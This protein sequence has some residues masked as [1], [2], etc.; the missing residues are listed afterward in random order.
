MTDANATPAKPSTL[1]SALI[2]ILKIVLSL[3][4]IY[5]VA[6]YVVRNWGEI[7]AYEW[8]IN[9]PLL[10]LSV[11]AHLL[12]LTIQARVWCMVMEGF[13]HRVKLSTSFK[14]SYIASLARYVPGKLWPM[15]GMAVL[16]KQAKID[17]R[18]SVASWAIAT[19]FGMPASFVVGGICLLIHSSEKAAEISNRLGPGMYIAA[20]LVTIASL[21]LLFAP[22]ITLWLYNLLLKLMKKPGVTFSLTIKQG[23]MIYLGYSLS[24]IAYGVSF[25]L[26]MIS[27]L[28][29]AN[30]PLV[31]AIGTFVLGYMIGYIAIFTP[32]GFGVRELIVTL[33]LSP[34]IGA[35]S[36]GIAVASRIWNLAVEIIAL[37]IAW[38][39]KIR[40]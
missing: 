15:V 31:A 24:W 8:E 18:E 19:M 6:S 16:A 21:L 32:G 17:E 25:W 2:K 35:V 9:Y 37:V 12:T 22:N 40:P 4:V 28:P 1:R 14:I 26:F 7:T 27:I 29:H 30:V 11:V 10:I 23:V 36:A 38:R 5:Y 39:I 3:L 34:Y 13:G 33:L 20:A